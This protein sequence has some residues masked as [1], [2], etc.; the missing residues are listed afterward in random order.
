M[1]VQRPDP[2]AGIL[3]PFWLKA[4][5][6]GNPEGSGKVACTAVMEGNGLFSTVLVSPKVP[7]P[8]VPHPI[9]F[10]FLQFPS[11]VPLCL[12]PGTGW[13]VQKAGSTK[14]AA[15]PPQSNAEG[16][17]EQMKDICRVIGSP[18]PTKEISDTKG[19]WWVFEVTVSVVHPDAPNRPTVLALVTSSVH[20]RQ[21]L[22]LF[23]F[24]CDLFLTW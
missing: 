13:R 14:K 10:L 21:Q 24:N 6:E 3:F 22:S 1:T 9:P 12:T 18:V 20:S 15:V 2:G 7:V 17:C 23:H 4:L 8:A 19:L 11:G 16:L 5:G